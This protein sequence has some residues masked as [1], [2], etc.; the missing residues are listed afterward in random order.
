M[1]ITGNLNQIIR[2]DDYKANDS[3][4]LEWAIPEGLD[5]MGATCDFLTS[6]TVYPMSIGGTL[7]LELTHTESAAMPLGQLK[8]AVRVTQPGGDKITVARGTAM[9]YD[10]V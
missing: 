10:P 4:N 7:S 2:G 5:V 1:L 3:R 6:T 8:Y 9:V